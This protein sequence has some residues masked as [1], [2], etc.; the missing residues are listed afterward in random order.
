[1]SSVLIMYTTKRSDTFAKLIDKYHCLL[2]DVF[3]DNDVNLIKLVPKQTVFIPIKEQSNIKIVEHITTNDTI[4]DILT[5]YN[6]DITTLQY[7][8]NFLQL[9][10]AENQVLRI[11]SK[12]DQDFFQNLLY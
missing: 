1:M 9:I 12:L 8:N 5:L 2:K 4:G 11:H 7:F 10:L 6:I 3:Q